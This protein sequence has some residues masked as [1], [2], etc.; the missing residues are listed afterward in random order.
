MFFSRI[1]F[2]TALIAL[3]ENEIQKCEGKHQQ[4]LKAIETE[5]HLYCEQNLNGVNFNPVRWMI[6]VNNKLHERIHDIDDM[7]IIRDISHAFRKLLC[8]F[9][10]K[11]NSLESPFRESIYAQDLH[12]KRQY[13]FHPY[14][15]IR[16]HFK[17]LE[18]YP[19]LKLQYYSK[20]LLY[21]NCFF[22]ETSNERDTPSL[23]FS[24]STIPHDQINEHSKRR[25]S[26]VEMPQL[27]SEID[28]AREI[29][30]TSTT[31]INCLQAF[32]PSIQSELSNRD[33]LCVSAESLKDYK[34]NKH[35]KTIVE[36]HQ[37]GGKA[38][39]LVAGITDDKGGVTNL[40][41][42][43]LDGEANI[44]F[45][46]YLEEDG[47][48]DH[49]AFEHG[50]FFLIFRDDPHEIE[51]FNQYNKLIYD[52]PLDRLILLMPDEQTLE[53]LQHFL[54]ITSAHHLISAQ[55]VAYVLANHVFTYEQYCETYLNIS[56][57]HYDLR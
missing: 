29:L 33:E 48:K 20:D 37:S 15:L 47:V 8:Q 34:K 24:R 21:K 13:N 40:A 54:E 53:D 32:C 23:M 16:K 50:P 26:L 3:F 10:S 56:T 6:D 36:H 35:F 28:E 49:S 44:R 38:P 12:L 30:I 45:M 39:R 43:V 1:K 55:Q 31:Y 2:L 52:L 7:V 18:L 41:M 19:I 25:H 17:P 42:I 9:D 22:P 14:P 57:N 5:F 4:L 51:Q 46:G 27:I 11:I